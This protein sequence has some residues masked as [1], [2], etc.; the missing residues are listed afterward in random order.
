MIMEL[1]VDA[2]GTIYLLKFLAFMAR[3]MKGTGTAKELVAAF[4]NC[5]RAAPQCLSSPQ[6]PWHADHRPLEQVAD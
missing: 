6:S 5:H 2:N 1:D 3:K 4:P